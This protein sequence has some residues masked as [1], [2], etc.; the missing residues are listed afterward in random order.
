MLKGRLGLETARIPQADRHGALW[1]GRGN[2]V[3]DAGTLR[4]VTAG[5][6][7]LPSGDYAL[8]FQ[9]VSCLV[10][11]PGTTITHDVMRLCARHGTGIVAAGEAGVRLYASMPFGPDRSA[12]ARRQV[13]DWAD[14][15]RRT[16]VAR[17]MYAWRLGELFPDADITVLRGMEGARMKATYKRLSDAFG[18]QWA[19]RRF[20]RANPEKDSVGNAAINHAAAAVYGLAQVAVAITGTIPQLGFIHEEKSIAFALDV[21]DMVRDR[22][23]L[24]IAFAAATMPR[25][26]GDTLERVVRKTA[27]KVF[28]EQKV[29]A[30]MIDRI[31]ELF[32]DDDAGSDA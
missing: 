32:G 14:L 21:A 28:R 1:L 15:N 23:T 5:Y 7:D 13:E 10:L 31:K 20:D 30:L 2:L 27:I 8:P 25:R 17:R 22:V 24:P 9:T 29:V 26:P 16:H 18:V 11:Q 3:V 6:D 4:F 19:G 12:R